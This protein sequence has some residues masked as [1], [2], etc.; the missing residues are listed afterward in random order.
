MPIAPP[1][2]CRP[3]HSPTTF[4]YND[5]LDRSQ[6]TYGGPFTAQPTNVDTYLINSADQYTNLTRNA[7]AV[8]PVYDRAGNMT[9]VPVLPVTGVN[10]QQDVTA[11]ATWDAMNCLYSVDTGVTPLQSYRYDPFRRRIAA[12]SG[13]GTTPVRRFIYADWTTV[14]ER[15]FDAGAT[16]ASA[17]S[18]LERIYVDGPRMDEHLLT[19]IDRNGNRVL[20][21][22]N[23]NNMDID[24]DQWY[25]FLPNRLG[26]VTALLAANN[27]NQIL[28]YYLYTAF[29]EATVLPSVG[30]NSFDLSVNFAQSWQRSSP[31]HGN[32]YFLTGQ[33]FDDSS[34]LYYY[35]NRYS[36]PRSGIFTSR[37][38]SGYQ[39]SGLNL[40]NFVRNAP[41]RDLDP[42]G[43][44][45]T[46]IEAGAT[47]VWFG[48]FSAGFLL[49][50]DECGNWAV[51]VA[52]SLRVGEELGVG[53]GAGIY[54]G[55]LPAFIAGN[56]IDI[57]VTVGV[58]GVGVVKGTGGAGSG[59]RGDVGVGEGASIGY[60]GSKAIPRLSS[61]TSPC[62]CPPPPSCWYKPWTWF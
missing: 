25:Y 57:H 6:A 11:A 49:C 26:S 55:C 53:V 4:A 54:S 36:E 44:T 32:Y 16:P 30:N 43:L 3:L 37:D 48:G 14:E 23:L 29:G 24:A 42:E 39:G 20:D 40:Y 17:P 41:I 50:S 28:E 21:A 60:G 31:E 61:L 56:S 15:L 46:C 58:P 12:L 47:A 5:N 27:A 7:V 52:G 34:G 59:V 18:T 2:R 10:G 13:L 38:P 19:A 35:R 8:N 45:V 51:I 62:P 22:A 33:R 1:V 9:G